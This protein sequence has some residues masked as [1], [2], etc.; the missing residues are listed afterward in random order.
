LGADAALAASRAHRRDA[1]LQ[2]SEL[3]AVTGDHTRNF[4]ITNDNIATFAAENSPLRRG[5]T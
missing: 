4:V 5:D 3:A 1:T 2:R